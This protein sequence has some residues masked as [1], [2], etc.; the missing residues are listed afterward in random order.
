MTTFLETKRLILKHTDYSDLNNLI[1]LRSDPN[2]MKYIGDGAPQTK[3]DVERFLA[4]AIPYQKKYGFGFCSVFEKDSGNFIGQAGLFHLGSSE[5]Q[6]EIEI[7]YRFHKNYW[8]KGYATECA[9]ALIHWGFQQL[10]VQ[11]LVAVVDLK[12]LR[13]SH[14]LEKAG[15]VYI[16]DGIYYEKKVRKYAIYRN[17]E[18]ELV[19][20]NPQWPII[21][22]L[23]IK[24]L[25][26]V[27][28]A[29]NIV[30]IQHVGSTAIP[31][32]LAKPIIDIQIAVTSLIDAKLHFVN[33]LKKI[34]YQYWS[35]NPD[36][37][38]L[39][40][41]KGMPPYGEKRTH[42]V[43]IV[44]PS[45]KHWREKIQFRDYLLSHPDVAQEYAS[46]K[47]KLAE[48]Y[49]YDREQYTDE[50]TSFVNRIL[51]KSQQH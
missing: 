26:Q 2:V 1:E 23:E 18:I 44:E 9:K 13:S 35:E 50:K 49:R 43:H 48:L 41:V 28:P 25:Y 16:G 46:L 45:S 10:S 8:G 29:H 39:F 34:D 20:Y 17:E 40:F 30:D 51:Q 37:E 7:A 42:H 3:E 31:G 47:I 33:E 32:I 21:A 24:K 19:A 12:N 15:L 6:D 5:D 38:R 27:L 14:V 4:Y 11:K 36:P 22:E